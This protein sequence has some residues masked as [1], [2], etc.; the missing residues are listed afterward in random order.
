MSASFTASQPRFGRMFKALT[1][2]PV[3][4]PDKL[5]AIIYC[6]QNEQLLLETET[7]DVVVDAIEQSLSSGIQE[8]QPANTG[9]ALRTNPSYGSDARSDS[10]SS[11]TRRAIPSISFSARPSFSQSVKNGPI[12]STPR[13]LQGSNPGDV[14]GKGSPFKI[15]SQYMTNICNT[16]TGIIGDY[17]S[18]IPPDI[19]TLAIFKMKASVIIKDEIKTYFKMY[20]NT[21]SNSELMEVYKFLEVKDS[22]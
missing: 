14:K 2:L 3:A 5:K 6:L 22:V 12:Q 15:I 8:I 13:D 17:L 11:S 19:N 21:M 7:V 18:T 16:L 4:H 20:K 9:T 10:T 1:I